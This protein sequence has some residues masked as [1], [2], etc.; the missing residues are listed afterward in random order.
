MKYYLIAG[1]ASGDMHGANL[2]RGIM[3]ADKNPE[4]RFR[5][6]EKMQ[7][8][9]GENGFLSR[10]YKDTAVMGFTEVAMHIGKILDNLK[11]CKKDIASF[12]PDTVILI[13]YPGFNFKIAK[14]AKSKGYNVFYYIS[15]KVW[16]WKEGRIKLIRKYVDKLFIIFPFEI[17]Y[18]KNKG[19]DAIYEGNPLMDGIESR[20][21]SMCGKDEFLK[22]AGATRGK[23]HVAVLA[24]SRKM[25]IKYLL[26]RSLDVAAMNP[27]LEFIL[28]AAPAIDMGLYHNI[29]T[30]HCGK[31]PENFRIVENMTYEAMRYS[32]A[33]IISSGTASLEAAIIGVPQVV[34]YGASEISYLVAKNFVKLKYISLA[35]LILDKGIFKELIQH[36]CTPEKINDELSM[37]L[38]DSA[39]VENMEKDYESV[40]KALLGKG[41]GASERVGKAMCSLLEKR[42]E[43]KSEA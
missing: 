9:A 38:N 5:G 14:Y 7:E 33:A 29:I 28:A 13:D 2:I 21:S 39:Y 4:F 25:E 30:R 1:E 43:R 35:N 31:I 11:D 32:D 42:M 26:P 34:C 41:K 6:G 8:A 37:L 10:H 22:A 40:R 24:G 17:E 3:A 19:I 23:K 18:F 16:A 15:P 12:N 36:D 20:L 27:E